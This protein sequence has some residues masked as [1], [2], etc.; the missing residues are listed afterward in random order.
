MR[1]SFP[2]AVWAY[3]AIAHEWTC[4]WMWMCNVAFSFHR[5]SFKKRGEK[6]FTKV[7]FISYTDVGRTPFAT[8]GRKKAIKSSF[9]Q[10]MHYVAKV[11]DI[12]NKLFA[13]QFLL[14]NKPLCPPPFIL[15]SVSAVQSLALHS[16]LVL[17]LLED[18]TDESWVSKL[19]DVRCTSQQ[20][21]RAYRHGHR[22]SFV[23]G[24]VWEC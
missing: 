24:S 9:C 14:S 23:R 1:A 16:H 6:E 11:E 20:W 3:C 13:L 17:L 2:R 21:F 7:C 15:V 22:K 5:L 19:W 18:S 10:C 4:T 8:E 12:L